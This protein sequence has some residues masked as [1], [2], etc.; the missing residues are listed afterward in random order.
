M[1]LNIKEFDFSLSELQSLKSLVAKI[2]FID[3]NYFRISFSSWTTATSGHIQ[4]DRIHPIKGH[5]SWEIFTIN[6]AKPLKIS[7]SKFWIEKTP[8]SLEQRI[9]G[10]IINVDWDDIYQKTVE[11]AEDVLEYDNFS[12]DSNLTILKGYREE[13]R[14]LYEFTFSSEQQALDIPNQI[15]FFKYLTVVEET[16]KS[17]KDKN[18]QPLIEETI[19]LRNDL[20]RMMKSTLVEEIFK[21]L[22][23]IRFMSFELFME[24][25]D[26]NRRGSLQRL[27]Q[28]K[29]DEATILLNKIQS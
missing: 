14:S 27:I 7:E 6:F 1:N 9:R 20:G 8:F 22:S 5:I 16:L 4:L 2:E 12:F 11:W 23:K 26:E 19:S 10:E 15:S 24:T 18:L 29:I 13:L 25:Q 17:K 3:Q 28:G 21:L